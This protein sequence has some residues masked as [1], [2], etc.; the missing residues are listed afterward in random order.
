MDES[1]K[2]SHFRQTIKEQFKEIAL[3]KSE[4]SVLE[5]TIRNLEATQVIVVQPEALFQE[6][7][8]K[9]WFSSWF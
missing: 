9:G 6:E 5:A 8:K 1:K 4:K 3:L 7:P 2:I